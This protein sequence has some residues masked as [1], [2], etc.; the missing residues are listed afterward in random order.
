M[1]IHA[2]ET[3]WALKQAFRNELPAAILGRPKHGFEMPIDAWLR[4]PLQD[5]LEGTGPNSPVWDLLDE[6]AVRRMY[7]SHLAGVGRF[8]GILWAVMVFS[9]WAEKYLKGS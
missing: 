3:K 2:G 1:K 6:R 9:R 4:G 8:G 5:V 7:R